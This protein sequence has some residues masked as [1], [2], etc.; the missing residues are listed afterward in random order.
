[1]LSSETKAVLNQYRRGE[2]SNSEIADWLSGAEYDD[3]LQ[4]DER[5]ILASIRLI[6]VEVKEG[7]RNPE[8]IVSMV[9]EVL[10]LAEENIVYAD[11]SGSSTLR[12]EEPKF[13]FS[14]SPSRVQRVG[15]SP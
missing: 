10:A 7:E 3:S 14:S 2:I 4:T 9:A 1:M 15:I 12:Q 5:D 13:K 11:R 6:V 8:E